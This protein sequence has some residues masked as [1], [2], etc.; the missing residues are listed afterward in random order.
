MTGCTGRGKSTFC[1]FLSR[2]NKFKPEAPP[3]SETGWGDFGGWGAAAADL[4]GTQCHVVKDLL[5]EVTVRIID[6]PGYLATHNRTG[7]DKNDLAK[8]GKM[9]L[10]EFANALTLARGGIDAIFIA[11]RAAERYTREEELLM[12]FISHLQLWDHCILLFTHGDKAGKDEEYRYKQFHAMIKSPAFPSRCPVLH[13]M[14]QFV[15]SRFVIVESVHC[16]GDQKYYHSKVKELCAAI[17]VVRSKTGPAIGH[18]LLKLARSAFEASQIKLDM[19]EMLDEMNKEKG[20][21]Q[22]ELMQAQTEREKLEKDYNCLQAELEREKAEKTGATPQLMRDEEALQD[23]VLIELNAKGAKLEREKADKTGATPQSMKDEEGLQDAVPMELNSKDDDKQDVAATATARAALRN[24]MQNSPSG[25]EQVPADTYAQLSMLADDR[26][27]MMEE[28]NG[29]MQQLRTGIGVTF[30]R[31][32]AERIND[33]LR[34]H[35]V[36]ASGDHS[37]IV[38]DSNERDRVAQTEDA[39]RQQDQRRN[40]TLF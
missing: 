10:D 39:S 16:K 14:L 26:G 4:T 8:D 37:I 25:R 36:E 6:L 1:N 24:W 3:D 30:K 32:I 40:C 9:V 20:K 11:L 21:I 38:S 27:K 22:E 23:A 5:G 18:P 28:L 15:S 12:E 31:R 2:S 19:Q 13:K 17:E 34:K 33:I 35:N 7:N 29:L